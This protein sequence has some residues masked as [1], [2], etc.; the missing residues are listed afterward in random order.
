MIKLN[1]P[2]VFRETPNV[3]FLDITIPKAN[4]LDLVEHTGRSVSPPDR[5]KNK[6]W[7][8]HQYQTDNNRVIKGQRLFELF[9]LEWEDPHWFVFLDEE[10]GALEIPPGCM[11]RSYSGVRGS[12]L[13]NHAV[14]LPQYDETKEFIPCVT[15]HPS[16]F[17][18]RYH[19]ITRYSADFF[20][21][22]GRL[23]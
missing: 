11:H 16:E 18:P 5:N 23:P 4:G 19:G 20:I 10:S 14:R 15:S 21:K 6:C 22:H 3:R 9:Y 13:L 7:Y 8:C 17:S 2:R 1:K 12:L